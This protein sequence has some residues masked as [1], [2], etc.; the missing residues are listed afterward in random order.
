MDFTEGDRVYH[1]GFGQWGTVQSGAP[2]G[3]FRLRRYLVQFDCGGEPQACLSWD[4][5]PAKP[6]PL[7]TLR[8]VTINGMRVA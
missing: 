7:R 6:A 2:I 5:T 1:D 4:L 3:Q 8:L